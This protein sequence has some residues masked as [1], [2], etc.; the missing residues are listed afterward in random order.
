MLWVRAV[1]VWGNG[2][3]GDAQAGRLCG[4]VSKRAAAASAGVVRLLAVMLLAAVCALG[5][6]GKEADIL[7]TYH[8]TGADGV[9]V[10]LVLGESGKGTWATDEAD[11]ALTWEVKRGE[12]WLHTRS[13][14][15]LS[16]VVQSGGVIRMDLPGVGKLEFKQVK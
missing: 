10:E 12:V 3:V 7:G 5:G 8:A 4:A 9:E 16:G 15:V 6:C 1:L 11:V 13:G 2:A 14:G